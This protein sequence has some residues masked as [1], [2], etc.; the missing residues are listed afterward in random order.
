MSTF[1]SRKGLKK[2]ICAIALVSSVAMPLTPVLA[3]PVQPAARLAPTDQNT[4]TAADY[5][6]FNKNVITKTIDSSPAQSARVGKYIIHLAAAS[7]LGKEASTYTIINPE[8]MQTVSTGQLQAGGGAHFAANSE[9]GEIL[10]AATDTNQLERYTVT[11][12]GQ[13]SPAQPVSG[14]NFDPAEETLAMGYNKF[15]HSW[16]VLTSKNY[17]TVDSSGLLSSMPLPDPKTLDPAL[18]NAPDADTSE[19]YGAQYTHTANMLAPLPDG[20]FVYDSG[21][22]ISNE[23]GEVQRGYLLHFSKDAVKVF[24]DGTAIAERVSYGRVTTT[25]DGRVYRWS[26]LH[27]SSYQVLSY[28][29]GQFTVLNGK[30]SIHVKGLESIGELFTVGDKL[31][32]LDSVNNR[33]VILDKDMN[34]ERSI[35]LTGVSAKNTNRGSLN[36]V[37]L[38][39]GDIVFPSTAE[40]PQEFTTVVQ[41]N[42]LVSAQPEQQPAPEPEKQA[43]PQITLS[44]DEIKSDEGAS[45]TVSGTGFYG[46]QAQ[47][48]VYV[49]LV[50]KDAFPAH[51][52]DERDPAVAAVAFV[53]GADIQDGAFTAVLNVPGNTLDPAAEYVVATGATGAAQDDGAALKAGLLQASAPVKVTEPQKQA[54]PKITL[55]ATELKVDA[56]S[57]EVLVNGTGFHGQGAA[58]GVS[59]GVYEADEQGQPTGNPV[60][61]EALVHAND[62]HDGG[63]AASVTVPGSLL[64][65]SKK[66]VV[67]AK[68][69]NE[70]VKL[71]ALSPVAVKPAQP[72]ADP[73]LS[74]DKSELDPTQD[75]AVT[76]SGSGYVGAAAQNGVYVA[77]VEAEKWQ[78]GNTPDTHSVAAMTRIAAED[79]H[80]GQ[81]R[82]TL[83]IAAG[84]LD[85]SKKYLIVS[86]A[87]PELNKS[88]RSL[89]TTAEITLK[90]PE[91]PK[92]SPTPEPSPTPTPEQPKPSPSPTPEPSPTPTPEQ[93]K[94][95]PSP[96]PAPTPEPSPK[97]PEPSPSPTPSPEKPT[98][99]PTPTPEQPKPSP[100]PTPEQ[101]KPS[102]KPTPEQPKPSP[103]PTPEKPKPDPT[104]TPE[105]PKPSPTPSPEK[106]TPQPTPTP[107]QPKPSPKPTPE[108]P[109]PS[110]TPT[111]E[112]PK[113]DPTPTPEQPKPSPKPTPE[114]PKPQ[115][116]APEPPKPAQRFK[117]VY[118]TDQFYTEIEWLASTGITTG[119]PDNT[120]RPQNNIER[121]AMAAFFYRMAGSPRVMMPYR[122]PFK[123]VDASYPFYKEIVWMYQ[124]GITT[125][126]PDGTFRPN[127]SVSREAMAAFFYRQARDYRFYAPRHTSFVDV[128]GD[129]LFYTEISWLA[130]RGI[131]RGWDDRT[132][133]PGQAITRDA[134]A[135]FL[136]RYHRIYGKK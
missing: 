136:Y 86:F 8:T 7:A 61:N 11:E 65:A 132:Y 32:V 14:F 4:K 23:Q 70:G 87:S 97:A 15:T 33:I 110:P 63:F 10:I 12:D 80:D 129:N 18:A 125:G 127:D 109:K 101:P 60:G 34:V 31:G 53:K 20:S 102:P 66:Y 108:Q 24:D 72:V 64:D 92:P 114:K 56:E 89:D 115:P 3:T 36:A 107:E 130:D 75:N 123:D 39:N 37:A 1:Y 28:A 29:D 96:T 49:Y 79:V 48:G 73:K 83:N 112:K 9:T 116:P 118:P 82:A 51:S 124:Q 128:N 121:G 44:T 17:I 68:A 46:E 62:L 38:P 84:T 58:K 111:P 13:L 106:P 43:N 67:A 133:R 25:D 91:S 45:V 27:N 90:V 119:W 103:T 99:Q 120:Y 85:A 42:R 71:V 93:P 41:M 105:Q 100:T 94:P 134:M 55:S 117:D 40:D 113:P 35:S 126:Y 69:E 88:D 74:I 6:L 52:A 78:E 19:Y 47:H 5:N 98:P 50:R 22:T 16:G 77:V 54:D 95:S 2:G 131:S 122:S 59:V 76:V 135:A 104:P 57:N 21:T 81:F 26:Y 30:T